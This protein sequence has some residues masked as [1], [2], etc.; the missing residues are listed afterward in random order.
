MNIKDVPCGRNKFAGR[1]D[2]L[3]AAAGDLSAMGSCLGRPVFGRSAERGDHEL[4]AQSQVDER[5]SGRS[6]PV[7]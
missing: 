1:A 4:D 7:S 2:H 5:D 6:A 3:A